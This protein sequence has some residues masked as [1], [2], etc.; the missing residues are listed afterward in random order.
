LLGYQRYSIHQHRNTTSNYEEAIKNGQTPSIISK[1]TS[2]NANL[3]AELKKLQQKCKEYETNTKTRKFKEIKIQLTEYENENRR[4]KGI[5][6]GKG[7]YNAQLS[8]PNARHAEENKDHSQG[9]S[10]DSG[11]Y[12]IE[13]SDIT[14][15]LISCEQLRQLITGFIKTPKPDYIF[16][17]IAKRGGLENMI[18]T[19][20]ERTKALKH[21]NTN[22]SICIKEQAQKI[23]VN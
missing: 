18:K 13:N 6:E 3:H 20:E 23:S 14:G 11:L 2:E 16:D 12:P 4:L 21:A 9:M 7:I 1:L 17:A 8:S 19:D 22:Q 15:K 5:I 10:S